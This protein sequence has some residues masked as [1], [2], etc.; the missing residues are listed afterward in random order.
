MASDVAAVEVV[1]AADPAQVGHLAGHPDRLLGLGEGGLGVDVTA[2]HLHQ[3]VAAVGDQQ[4]LL[5]VDCVGDDVE[6]LVAG[7]EL[8]DGAAGGVAARLQ[9]G[10]GK[11]TSGVQV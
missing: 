3:R 2:G 4:M 8:G 1:H 5:P 11:W 9:I 10:Q 7:A 6:R